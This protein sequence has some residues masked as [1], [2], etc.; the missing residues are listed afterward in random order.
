V[1]QQLSPDV[2]LHKLTFFLVLGWAARLPDRLE[3]RKEIDP[4]SGKVRTV[5]RGHRGCTHSCL[6]LVLLL[7]L[8]VIGFTFGMS[9]LQQH[10][11]LLSAF[12]L[13]EL[14]AAFL[15]LV[16]GIVL[17]VLADSMTTRGVQVMWPESGQYHMTPE[18]VRFN[19]GAWQEYAILWGFIF[20]VGVLVGLGIFGF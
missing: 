18:V 14:F 7:A 20:L 12:L 1:M 15:G 3:E 11:L 5:R 10:H 17:H 13:K 16:G 4:E 9:Y 19:N 2:L 6:F 8:F